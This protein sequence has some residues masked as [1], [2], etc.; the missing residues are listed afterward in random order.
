MLRVLEQLADLLRDDNDTVQSR[1]RGP[2]QGS[3][4]GSMEQRADRFACR[5]RGHAR[6]FCWN[7]PISPLAPQGGERPRPSGPGSSLP[8]PKEP[9]PQ[10]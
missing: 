6:G 2:G 10:C 9:G 8:D 7:L 4:A 1:R 3:L 5:A